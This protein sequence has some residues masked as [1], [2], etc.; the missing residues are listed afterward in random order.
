MIQLSS[1]QDYTVFG[2]IL[3]LLLIL[4][5]IG[6]ECANWRYVL[7]PLPQSTVALPVLCSVWTSPA[8]SWWEVVDQEVWLWTKVDIDFVELPTSKAP[9]YL[10]SPPEGILL[11]EENIVFHFLNIVFVWVLIEKL[12]VSNNSL[13]RCVWIRLTELLYS[14]KQVESLVFWFVLVF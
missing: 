12:Y 9:K 5:R 2:R 13:L 14:I 7:F 11:Q 8:S 6:K 10:P 1:A 3:D 4:V